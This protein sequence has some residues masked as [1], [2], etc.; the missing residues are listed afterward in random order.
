MTEEKTTEEKKSSK[1]SWAFPATSDIFFDPLLDSLEIITRLY[2]QPLSKDSLKAGMP[3]VE[4]RFTFDVFIRSARRAGL[5][6][7]LLKRELH[8]L[9]HLVAPCVMVLTNKRACVL[10][11]IDHDK[12]IVT[13]IF[14]ASGDGYLELPIEEFEEYYDGHIILVKPLFRFEDRA[15]KSVALDSEHWFWGTL[16]MSWRIYRDVLIASL[17]INV[18]ALVTPL[19]T[20]NVY[21]RVVPNSAIDTMW[22]LA[23]GA[24]VVFTFDIS[25]KVTRTYF[26]D[27]AGK[28][29]DLVLSAKLFAQVLG[30]RFEKR[31]ESVGTFS[32]NV[33]EFEVVRDFITSATLATLVDLPFVFIFL[34]VI[35]ILSGSLVWVPIAGIVIILFGTLIFQPLMK[36]ATEKSSRASSQKNGLLIEAIGGLE[37]IKATCAESVMQSRWE[38]AVS[39]IS[40]CNIRSRLLST[41]VGS[42]GGY[43]NQIC[44]IGIIIAGVYLIK[45]GDMTMG[46]LIA[47]MMLSGRAV[48]PIMKI[49]NL[50]TRYNSARSAYTSLTTIM[51]LEQERPAEKKFL[52]IKKI[53]GAVTFKDV[54]FH[55]PKAEYLALAGVSFKIKAGER[56]GIIGRLGSGKSTIAKI[57]LNLYRPIK[58]RVEVDD[59]DLSQLNPADLRR[60]IGVVTQDQNLFYGTLR[61]NIVMGVPYIEESAMLRAVHLSGIM[62]FVNSHPDG[63]DMQVGEQGHMLS[64]G[65]R[66]CVLLARAFLLDPP[67]L[68]FDEPTSAMDNSSEQRFMQRLKKVLPGK[69]LIFITHKTSLL[70]LV[71]RLLVM[72]QGQI[73]TQGTKNDVFAQLQGKAVQQGAQSHA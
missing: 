41:A 27:L 6:S 30:M 68:L 67:I 44:T 24:F 50:A 73:V 20:R 23:I 25:M 16:M 62:D 21:D 49:A 57:L 31:P 32:R 52:G 64:G 39:Y 33:Q 53:K 4:N 58:G 55:Y 70:Q 48:G 13:V 61:E 22:A 14:P 26:L 37:S 40:E 65:Q 17:L 11:A 18:F 71:D 54:D 5:S 7:R 34:G 60:H 51:D 29:A 66:Q 38:A 8:N 35:W 28:K 3:L 72:D 42:L 47:A 15:E 45:D 19:F 63:L 59:I 69:T 46:G 56:I 9:T 2:N 1:P 36:E 10:T 12:G 43:I